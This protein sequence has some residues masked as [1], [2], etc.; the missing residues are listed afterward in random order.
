[1]PEPNAPPATIAPAQLDWFGEH[2]NFTSFKTAGGAGLA[3]G[4]F[5]NMTAYHFENTSTW[6]RMAQGDGT[7]RIVALGGSVSAGCGAL[8]PTLACQA[9]E[10][11][12]RRLAHWLEPLLQDSHLRA[13]ISA[14]GKNAVSSAFFTQCTSTFI[15]SNADIVIL[16]LET[17]VGNEGDHGHLEMLMHRIRQL[18]PGAAIVF[19][20]W[21]NTQAQFAELS[22]SWTRVSMTAVRER[23]VK[24]N[25]SRAER[26]LLALAEKR[27]FDLLLAAGI[28]VNVRASTFSHLKSIFYSDFVHPNA[29]GH[30]LLAEMT[31]RHIVRQL[32]RHGCEAP[33]CSCSGCN[34]GDRPEMLAA[35]AYL[36]AP[37]QNGPAKNLEARWAATRP[38][39][40][41][42]VCYLTADHLPVAKAGNWSLVDEGG[43]KKI[44]KLGYL[45]RRVGDVLRLGPI[46]PGTC[47][48]A[49]VNLGYLRSW[50]P[51]QGAF[52]IGCSNIELHAD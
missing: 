6:R 40:G 31:A 26:V 41:K 51:D 18:A 24:E 47:G 42:E 16:E 46:A 27:A 35:R 45:S 30:D 10:S 12:V 21:P 43:E 33:S 34:S 52:T 5:P 48:R 23:R 7:I 9:S 22:R 37:N 38:T 15:H 1:M 8:H 19:V 20:G 50:R 36:T 39:A 17:T 29:N 44:K 14:W 13:E 49:R 3:T 32:R 11:W 4:E 2:R 28:L 25:L